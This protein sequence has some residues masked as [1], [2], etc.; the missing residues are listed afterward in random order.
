MPGA[1]DRRRTGG[2]R[3]RARQV[4]NDFAG[5]LRVEQAGVVVGDIVAPPRGLGRIHQRAGSGS[6][7][8]A[9]EH[10]AVTAHQVEGDRRRIMSIRRLLVE[11][12]PVRQAAE[13]G[14]LRP[15]AILAV[16]PRPI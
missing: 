3:S 13:L 10:G 12:S 4:G 6:I 16:P 15:A 7:I 9:G 2:W 14:Q 5:S 11:L 1:G 8:G